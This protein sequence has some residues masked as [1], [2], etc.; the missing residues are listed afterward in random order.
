MPALA[1]TGTLLVQAIRYALGCVADL[2]P[3]CLTRPTP[4]AEWDVAALLRHVNDS[5]AGLH[6]GITTGRIS[7]DPT[8]PSTHVRAHALVETF[9]ER[10]AQL[11]AVARA[12]GQD[13]RLITIADRYVA[14]SRVAAVGTVEVAV[15]GWDV[16]T[17]CG[18]DQPI[19][20]GLAVG[21]L[22]IVPLVVTDAIRLTR[23]AP[24]VTMSVPATP[25]DRLV[26]LLGRCPRI[27]TPGPGH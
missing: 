16:A 12:L 3:P 24:P 22:K 10:A 15:H 18:R 7:L 9:R 6:E 5:L 20:T 25:S 14:E 4:C 21:I 19:P 13:D 1:G 2:A 23:F 8:E 11:L 17:A 26:A 27:S